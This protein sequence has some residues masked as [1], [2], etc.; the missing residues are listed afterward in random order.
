MTSTTHRRNQAKATKNMI[1]KEIVLALLQS[2]NGI[3][4]ALLSALVYLLAPLRDMPTQMERMTAAFE[5]SIQK[6]EIMQGEI[7]S[8]REAQRYGISK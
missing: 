2:P 5:A 3:G 6:I 8:I 1:D 4:I 7:K